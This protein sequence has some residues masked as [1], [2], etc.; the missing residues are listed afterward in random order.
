ML[1]RTEFHIVI[2]RI[3]E[4]PFIAEDVS[5]IMLDGVYEIEDA[6]FCRASLAHRVGS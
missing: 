4:F 6:H 1:Q 5:V 2:L 3:T